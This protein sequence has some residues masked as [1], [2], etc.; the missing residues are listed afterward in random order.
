[1]DSNKD[2]SL[3]C[4]ACQ[5]NARAVG[6]E[7]KRPVL[8]QLSLAE[9][10]GVTR[11]IWATVHWQIVLSQKRF[12]AHEGIKQNVWW[13]DTFCAFRRERIVCDHDFDYLATW[14]ATWKKWPMTNFYAISPHRKYT[15]LRKT[16]EE[17]CMLF[18][19]VS[20]PSSQWFLSSSTPKTQLSEVRS[21]AWV[22][23]IVRLSQSQFSEGE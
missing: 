10:S 17:G 20:R 22:E 7:E 11:Y 12:L 21:E 8:S 19:A 16:W 1:M 13:Y 3:W 15:R 14:A 4:T 5:A 2:S 9:H 6:R 18:T 23:K